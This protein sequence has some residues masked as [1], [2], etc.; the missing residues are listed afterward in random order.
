MS[1]FTESVTASPAPARAPAP[2]QPLPAPPAPASERELASRLDRL[3]ALRELPPLVAPPRVPRADPLSPVGMGGLIQRCGPAGCTC[4][5][6][7]GSR[8]AAVAEPVA[9]LPA[10]EK[11][12]DTSVNTRGARVLQRTI[13]GPASLRRPTL[14]RKWPFRGKKDRAVALEEF[15][16]VAYEHRQAQER[17]EAPTDT[18]GC[19]MPKYCD[20]PER[21]GDGMP[22]R[23]TLT[24]AADREKSH[25]IKGLLTGSVG[26]TWVKFSTDVGELS[27]YGL[28]PKKGFN[29]LMPNKTVDGCI[30]HPDASHD[31]DLATDLKQISYDLKE[32]DWE[33]ARHFA[34][35]ECKRRPR[36]NLFTNNC[37]TFAIQV[38]RTAG[39][40]PPSSTWMAVDN[41]NAIYEG[42]EHDVQAQRDAVNQQ[43]MERVNAR[44]NARLGPRA[45]TE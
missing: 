39:I 45:A 15:D 22:E 14:Q 34:V 19:C 11:S 7:C 27:S 24:I 4:G 23:F 5:G 18:R 44:L 42:I 3:R 1:A 12:G 32:E 25:P 29:K 43:E 41:P 6:T 28:W 2:P 38:A 30:R 40:A 17:G 26:H 33:R 8:P 20:M 10:R 31:G 36:Y 21:K 13:M 16:P 35:A 9:G 37:T